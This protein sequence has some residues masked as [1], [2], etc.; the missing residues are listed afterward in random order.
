V[1]E[2]RACLCGCGFMS[3]ARFLP[4]HDAKLHSLVL[5]IQRQKADKSELT[6]A[7]E[8]LNYLNTAPWMNDEIR[9]AIGL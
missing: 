1:I 4:G 5:K 8:T 6:T 9:A 3:K 7:P 2:A